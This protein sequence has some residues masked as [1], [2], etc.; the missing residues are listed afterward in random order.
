[1]GQYPGA[2]IDVRSA[3]GR[4][5]FMQQG[6]QQRV[7]PQHLMPAPPPQAPPLYGAAPGGPMYL[8]THHG[9]AGYPPPPPPP[10][11]SG[12]PRCGAADSTTFYA[13]TC[14][15]T[16]LP[17]FTTLLS[18]H[19]A[20]AGQS[21]A[22][23]LPRDAPCSAPSHAPPTTNA[24]PAQ[25]APCH[26]A[27]PS[28][29]AAATPKAAHTEG[30]GGEHQ[31]DCVWRGKTVYGSYNDL[32]DCAIFH[33]VLQAAVA[34]LASISRVAGYRAQT[35]TEHE[36]TDTQ[37]SVPACRTCLQVTEEMLAN[38]FSECGT[39]VDCRI[40]GDP[41]SA[42]RFAFIEFSTIAEAQ[43]VGAVACTHQAQV[44]SGM[45]LGSSPL[46][47]LPSK[48]AIVPVSR[49]LM[50]RSNDEVC[51]LLSWAWFLLQRSSCKM[52]RESKQQMCARCEN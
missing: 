32:Q 17:V 29:A 4:A 3:G 11:H 27:P 22:S 18:H 21:D 40:C 49:E 46:R 48:T 35:H 28:A 15:L 7:T 41:N 51:L 31:E 44:K 25:P 26:A 23:S 8:A 38:S 9:D 33:T 37:L 14:T 39:V 52:S 24:P 45:V 36:R 12:G 50:P 5:L 47:V 43:R 2:D 34:L 13:S 16:A 20:C 19:V 10:P 6:P 30:H 1:M 42:M